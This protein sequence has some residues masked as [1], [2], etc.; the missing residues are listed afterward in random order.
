MVITFA[1]FIAT[2]IYSLIIAKTNTFNAYGTTSLFV[3]G[4]ICLILSFA[5]SSVIKER[6]QNVH[7]HDD[8]ILESVQKVNKKV[9]I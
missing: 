5:I 1:S 6:R 7:K 8:E 9:I 2:E 4:L 3:I